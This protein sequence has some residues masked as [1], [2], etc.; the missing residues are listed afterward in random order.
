MRTA[1]DTTS[2]ADLPTMSR[3]RNETTQIE[4]DIQM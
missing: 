3:S 1:I 2:R 4:V